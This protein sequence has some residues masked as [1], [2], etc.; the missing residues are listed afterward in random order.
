MA[1]QF[2]K[3][4][5]DMR[6]ELFFI[7][8]GLSMDAFTVSV[9]K[10]LA[11]QGKCQKAGV[12]VGAW[13]GSFQALMPLLGYLCGEGVGEYITAVSKYLALILLSLIGINMIREALT[14][15]SESADPSLSYKIM[16]PAAIAT[17]IDA[18]AVGITLAALQVSITPSIL[19]IGCTT[20]LISCAGVHVGN[21]FGNKFGRQA[22]VFGGVVLICIGLRIFIAGS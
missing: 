7:A 1:G 20:F 2:S 11:I 13:F 4:I 22:A 21:I 16:L 9:C 6:I 12:V 5:Y 18:F 8:I 3:A 17:S 14:A 10:G 19:L 15:G